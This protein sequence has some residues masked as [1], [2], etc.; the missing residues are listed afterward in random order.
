VY[1][2]EKLDPVRGTPEGAGLE[3]MSQFLESFE[4]DL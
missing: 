3:A 1:V 2:E 4:K